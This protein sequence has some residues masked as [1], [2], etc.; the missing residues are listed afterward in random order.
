MTGGIAITG[1][2]MGG[3]TGYKCCLTVISMA[4]SSVSASL[5]GMADGYHED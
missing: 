2:A 5:S 3:R 1:V 4:A